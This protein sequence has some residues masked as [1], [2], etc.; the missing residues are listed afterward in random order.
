M[1][2]VKNLFMIRR[3]L[4]WLLRTSI[5]INTIIIVNIAVIHYFYNNYLGTDLSKTKSLHHNDKL[6]CYDCY[7]EELNDKKNFCNGC[8]KKIQGKCM[9]VFGM[10]YHPEHF[11]CCICENKLQKGKYSSLICFRQ[12]SQK[13]TIWSSL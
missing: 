3:L 4:R 5:I 13:N 2:T 9:Q 8:N 10:K 11:V 6:F 1:R 12:Q 7:Q